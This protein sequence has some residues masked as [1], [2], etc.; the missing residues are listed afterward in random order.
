MTANDILE[1]IA[2]DR[3]SMILQKKSIAHCNSI[4]KSKSNSN[5]F[6]MVKDEEVLAI[7]KKLGPVTPTQIKRELNVETFVISAVLSTLSSK[8]IVKISNVKLGSSPLYYLPEQK[9]KLEEFI[10]LL[11]D[12]DQATVN[13]LKEQRVLK[14]Y[15]QEL[16][17]RVSLR[18][19]KDY[20]IPLK[21]N[22]SET[23]S[24]LFWRYFLA[25]EEEVKIKI[26][27]IL[28][29]DSYVQDEP[30]K[31][32][33]IE[34][35]K[36][37]LQNQEQKIQDKKKSENEVK[38]EVKQEVKPEVKQE[39]KVKSVK[40]NQIN[41]G[42]KE[43]EKQITL[44]SESKIEEKLLNDK[45]FLKLKEK[46]NSKG[47]IIEKANSIRKGKEF[48]LIILMN[49]AIGKTRFFAKYKNKKRCNDADISTAIVMGQ[50]KN[51]PIAFITSGELTKKTKTQLNSLF[52][53]VMVVE[54][55]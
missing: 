4:Q 23:E 53:N 32:E 51:L 47:I 54:K 24:V 9:Q 17:V 20:A 21:I 26:R 12:K 50:S 28:R 22:I 16:L 40:S 30:E 35:K 2:K 10:R 5:S 25:N 27:K 55:F 43:S 8:K 1:K 38:Q 15:D 44:S 29:P 7:V 37:D 18:K 39:V 42:K 33:N 34:D 3:E 41:H 36:E 46:F 11:N 6:K 31:I 45:D 49:T 13:L 19:I 52:K 48:D 14:D